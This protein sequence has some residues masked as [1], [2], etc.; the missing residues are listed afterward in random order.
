MSQMAIHTPEPV[1]PVF[2]RRR[3]QMPIRPVASKEKW[4]AKYPTAGYRKY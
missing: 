2:T 3:S 4:N 1:H